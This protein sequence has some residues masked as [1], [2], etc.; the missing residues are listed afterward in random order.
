MDLQIIMCIR[1]HVTLIYPIYPPL[2]AFQ[3]ETV[4]KRAVCWPYWYERGGGGEHCFVYFGKPFM[5]IRVLL[6]SIFN[7]VT[8]RECN[9]LIIWL[10]KWIRL[11]YV[12]CC[13]SCCWVLRPFLTSYVSVASD[14]EREKS[15]KF[16]S[17]ALISAWG[18]FTCRKFTTRDPRLSFPSEG[19]NTRDFY[20]LKKSIDPGRDRTREAA[21]SV[22]IN[23]KALGS[24]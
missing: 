22:Y 3:L 20:A 1:R 17:V 7:I 6:P 19:S 23:L 11:G 13:S 12:S 9:R 10:F 5:N 4:S 16:C 15:D 14:K 8:L 21:T 2:F 24:S 18:S